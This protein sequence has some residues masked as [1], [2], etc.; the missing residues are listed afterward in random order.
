MSE[1]NKNFW[2]NLKKNDYKVVAIFLGVFIVCIPL[3][4]GWQESM[5]K[6]STKNIFKKKENKT[7]QSIVMKFFKK[8]NLSL[9]EKKIFV[10]Y[11]RAVSGDDCFDLENY[12]PTEHLF[13]YKERCKD[14]FEK[15]LKYIRSN[16]DKE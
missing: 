9:K 8:N 6:E 2:K 1:K 7:I 13:V 5:Q 15:A 3:Y 10:R 4:R 14:H 16:S 12:D 11:V